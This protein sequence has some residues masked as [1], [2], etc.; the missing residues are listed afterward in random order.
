MQNLPNCVNLSAPNMRCSYN[1][2]N[3]HLSAITLCLVAVLLLIRINPVYYAAQFIPVRHVAGQGI[4]A[5]RQ[6]DNVH[7]VLRC[8]RGI[9][10]RIEVVAV[11]Q[12]RFAGVP[13][14][15]FFAGKVGE[16]LKMLKSNTF[17]G[18]V[19]SNSRRVATLR[20]MRL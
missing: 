16:R 8:Q 11:P 13:F 14:T 20:N 7:A 12:I 2:N 9:N 19:L 1:K 6:A 18:I 3:N 5:V 10:E 15:A 4:A 17:T